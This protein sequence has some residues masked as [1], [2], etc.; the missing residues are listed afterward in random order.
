MESLLMSIALRYGKGKLTDMGLNYAAKLLGI[1]QQQ[2]PKYT[3]G[4]PFTNQSI[5]PI[6]M[7]KRSALNTGIKSLISSP[8]IVPLT[9]GAGA[10]YLLNK[11]RKKL[12][13]YDTQ[14]AYEDART[15]R[16]ANKRL[17]KI[18]DRM[19][20]G[21]NYGN[22]EEALLDSGAG[23]VDI[24][25]TIYSGPDYQ[26]ETTS[27]RDTEPESIENITRTDIPDRGRGQDNVGSSPSKS[28]PSKS[29]PSRSSSYS[30]SRGSNFGGRFHNARG[31][32]ASL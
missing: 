31:G 25:G 18:T 10:I 13:G 14:Q 20:D 27:Y 12:T 23:A 9:L 24:D 11:N 22:Y 7:L 28:S 2:N 4:M 1:D 15:E 30:S 8:A 29:S 16:I 17:D 21:K 26:G 3:Y 19:I 5:D 6:N 32:I